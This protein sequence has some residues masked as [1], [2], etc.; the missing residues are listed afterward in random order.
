MRS[1]YEVVTKTLKVHRY[2]LKKEAE[3]EVPSPLVIETLVEQELPIEEPKEP[4][5]KAKKDIFYE[6]DKEKTAE[7]KIASVINE[8]HYYEEIYPADYGSNFSVRKKKKVPKAAII[9]AVFMT[10]FAI[11]ILYISFSKI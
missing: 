1:E 6:E 8:D 10:I 3:L 11:V 9:L 5:K 7:E 4:E 2:K